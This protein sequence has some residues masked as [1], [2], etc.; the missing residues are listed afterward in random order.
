MR[1]I[2][3]L[4]TFIFPIFVFG[5]FKFHDDFELYNIDSPLHHQSHNWH[6]WDSMVEI[7]SAYVTNKKS[8]SQSNSLYL[9]SPHWAGGP[10]DL[11]FPFTKKIDEGLVKI[12]MM[13]YIDDSAGAYF[14]LQSSEKLGSLYA[15][16]ISFDSD[17]SIT[18]S[19]YKLKNERIKIGF[20]PKLNGL[21]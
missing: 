10:T 7:Q 20:Y 11:V 16:H 17:S 12:E 4:L 9:H 15:L 2:L 21:K 19:N 13:M 3:I 1:Y 8:F 18:I 14:N 6:T 5:Q